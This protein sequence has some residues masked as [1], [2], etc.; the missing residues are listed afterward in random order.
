MIFGIIVVCV[1]ASGALLWLMSRRSLRAQVLEELDYQLFSIELPHGTREGK[2]VV[3]EIQRSEQ[4]IA[5]LASC[6]KPFTFEIAVPVVGE[7][8]RFF[9][10]MPTSFANTFVRQTHALWSDARIERTHDYTIFN[11]AGVVSGT[12]LKLSQP[13]ALP[14]RTYRDLV[15]DTFSSVVG[16]LAK[17]G[18]IGE[19]GAVQYVIRPN[20][21][22]AKQIRAAIVS[23]KKGGKLSDVLKAGSFGLSAKDFHVAATKGLAPAMAEDEKIIDDAAIRA[24]EAKIAKPLFDVDIRI[25]ASA[26]TKVQADAIVDGIA[27]GFGQL[28]APERNALVPEKSSSQK[29]L[30]SRFCFREFSGSSGVVLN[31]EELA[32]VFHLPTPFTEIPRVKHASFIEAPPPPNLPK[33][34]IAL[35]EARYR[36]ESVPVRLLREDRRR[37]LY[38]VGQ[39]GTGKTVC[40]S[41][42]SQQDITGG[43]GL[44]VMDPNGDFFQESLARVPRER[45]KDLVVFDPSD[46]ERPVGL[47]MLEYD[48]KFPEHKTFIINEMLNI[49]DTLY[50]LKTTGGPMFEQYLRFSLLLLMDDPSEGFT[51]VDIPRVLSDAPFRKRLLAKCTNPIAKNFWEKEAEKAGGEASLSNMVPYITSKFN[52]FLGNDYVRP[53]IEQSKTTLNF[54]KIMDEQQILL[55]NLS[56]G[57]IGELNASL[58]GMIIVGKLTL[59]AFSRDDIPPEARKDFYLYID[60]FQNFTTP[61]I[62]TIM[63]EARKYR[64]CLVIAH[65]FI[66]QLKDNI[67]NAVFGNVGSLVAFR[68]GADDAQFLVKQFAPVFS[69]QNLINIANLNAHAK[70]I[71][72]NQVTLPFTVFMPFPPRGDAEVAKLAREYS[73]LTYGRDRAE[74]EAEAYR[75]L[76]S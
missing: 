3:D 17:I 63:S 38:I 35:G 64:L 49:F 32:S 55:V 8:I 68:V 71:V 30:V 42:L 36:G 58:L 4:L 24:L 14:L 52:T 48:P 37:H 22:H 28:A 59:A 47:N 67:R 65:Q 51:I 43:E 70:L 21:K 25:V 1:V 40:L 12:Q 19:G 45:V 44:C 50:D 2:Q 18:E 15:S 75:R 66:G 29:S 56:K 9:A 31:T 10:A 23:L 61:A 34:G 41:R 16:G 53:I 69:E 73:R 76:Q 74:V 13:S 26:P 5:A 11:H 57:R 27:S 7:E 72:Q 60:E 20:A 33:E 46:L 54:R 62:A 39:T 6:R